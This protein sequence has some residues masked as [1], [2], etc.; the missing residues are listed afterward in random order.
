MAVSEEVCP[1]V[2]L[3]TTTPGGATQIKA[4]CGVGAQ[5][6]DFRQTTNKAGAECAVVTYIAAAA[7]PA[8]TE[9]VC[10][11]APSVQGKP[12]LTAGVN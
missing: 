8:R 3:T 7:K 1:V 12:S 4:P 9:R 6:T 5:I 11:G 2:F 10:L